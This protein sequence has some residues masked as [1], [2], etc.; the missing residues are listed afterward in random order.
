M[1]RP[2]NALRGRFGFGACMPVEATSGCEWSEYIL[3]R[4]S[5]AQFP[6]GSLVLDI[7]FGG[8][9]QMARLGRAGNRALGVEV[10]RW[11]AR[12]AREKGLSVCVGEAERLPVA[13]ASFDGVISKVVIPY[14]DEA[15]AIAEIAR[16][17]KPGAAGRVSY[18]GA[19]YFLKYLLTG[20]QWK[21]RAYGARVLAATWW[22]ALRGT[23]LP[24]FLGDSLYQSR[25]RLAAHY[26]RAGLEL[27]EDHNS[28]RFLGFPVFIYHVLR[29]APAGRVG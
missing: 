11:L 6:P 13:S 23:R 3:D 4:F 27:V 22:Y 15:R 26:R 29:R 28:P 7:G 16:A 17:L 12:R 10:D 9:E 2:R 5:F 25:R 14:T 24:G 1:K 8:G 18:H 19:G 20:S 21:R